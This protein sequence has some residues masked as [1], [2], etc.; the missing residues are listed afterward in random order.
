[1]TTHMQT[2]LATAT[3]EKFIRD[4]VID[5]RE[6]TT[7]ALQALELHGPLKDIVQHHE[8]QGSLFMPDTWDEVFNLA[9][10]GQDRFV[11]ETPTGLNADGL[12][13]FSGG[14]DLRM[15]VDRRYRSDGQYHIVINNRA[16]ERQRSPG[17]LKVVHS[18]FPGTNKPDVSSFLPISL[19]DYY[20]KITK[21]HQQKSGLII[22]P[23]YPAPEMFGKVAVCICSLD[24]APT[25]LNRI[26]LMGFI[27]ASHL[28]E[29]AQ[30]QLKPSLYMMNSHDFS[31]AIGK[32][33]QNVI[34]DLQE[35]NGRKTMVVLSDTVYGGPDG[36]KTG[37]FGAG[38]HLVRK[39]G[40]LIWHMSAAIG[41]NKRGNLSIV[42]LV[43]KSGAGKTETTQIPLYEPLDENNP[44]VGKIYLGKNQQSEDVWL[45]HAKPVDC[46]II[47]DDLG[48]SH[49]NR[50]VQDDRGRLVIIDGESRDSSLPNAANFNRTDGIRHDR[51]DDPDIL[52]ISEK[53]PVVV[54][55]VA[56]KDKNTTLDPR[57]KLIIGYD[58][59]GNPIFHPNDREIYRRHQHPRASEARGGPIS[60]MIY[61][62]KSQPLLDANGNVQ[63]SG[64]LPMVSR[65]E[66]P[67]AIG[68]FGLG[69]GGRSQSTLG[70][71]KGG[72]NNDGPGTC[73]VFCPDSPVHLMNDMYIHMMLCQETQYYHITTGHCGMHEVGY[74]GLRVAKNRLLENDG[75]LAAEGYR[76]DPD[77]PLLGQIPT[78]LVNR[79]PETNEELSHIPG[80]Y[81]SISQQ[82]GVHRDDVLEG[83][84]LYRQAAEDSVKALLNESER[85]QVVL[86]PGA[87]RILE[88]IQRG[89]NLDELKKI[90]AQNQSEF[91]NE[92]HHLPWVEQARKNISEGTENN[93]PELYNL[94]KDLDKILKKIQQVDS[95][96]DTSNGTNGNG[97]NGNG[98]AT[99]KQ[100]A[101]AI[102]PFSKTK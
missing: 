85:G 72:D 15:H 48:F 71:L 56:H 33:K 10:L 39:D 52:L 79:H 43:G 38:Y 93:N 11:Y 35:Y 40:G 5:K 95:E 57:D 61:S 75:E 37:E 32:R 64:V 80:D 82:D 90:H 12:P 34:A 17:A 89:D 19:D 59:D 54:L 102:N 67:L 70:G 87:K 84:K 53:Y 30:G 73:A 101:E 58:E 20:S 16:E 77:M 46:K 92:T 3:V 26:G 27:P 2:S 96:S 49:P 99:T 83:Y 60:A 6:R 78:G 76:E 86:L 69:L 74:H 65:L 45:N 44:A 13:D 1:M 22:A 31:D 50:L 28:L 97:S 81:F 7:K 25:I 4:T 98:K 14:L 55:N 62:K 23:F 24:A 9:T 29:M 42:G 51:V 41:L 94:Q 21:L 18:K 63:S 68:I 8:M 91:K 66:T 100:V 36:K 47:C 88:W